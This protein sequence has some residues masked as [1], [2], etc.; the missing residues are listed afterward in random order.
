MHDLTFVEEMVNCSSTAKDIG[1]VQLDDSI[2]MAPHITAAC[3]SA[4]FHLRNI[5]KIRKFLTTETTYMLL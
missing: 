1:V 3:K 2:S 5:S 4:F